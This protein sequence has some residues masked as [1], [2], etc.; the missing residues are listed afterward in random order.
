M[1]DLVRR[2]YHV[3]IDVAV[4]AHDNY[5]KSVKEKNLMTG[6]AHC[7]LPFFGGTLGKATVSF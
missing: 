3:E 7:G 1:P 2:V 4:R 5:S 6:S